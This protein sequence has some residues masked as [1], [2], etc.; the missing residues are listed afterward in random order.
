[1]FDGMFSFVIPK[2]VGETSLYA[3]LVIEQ[4]DMNGDATIFCFL[5]RIAIYSNIDL[6]S[7]TLFVSACSHLFPGIPSRYEGHYLGVS[8]R[9]ILENEQYDSR[10]YVCC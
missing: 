1:M 3:A 2:S 6:A 7:L 9:A 4:S 10:E 8:H 5:V